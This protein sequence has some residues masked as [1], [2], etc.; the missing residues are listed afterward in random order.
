M[1]IRKVRG[2]LMPTRKGEPQ[3]QVQNGDIVD[4][5][6]G[7]SPHRRE[8]ERYGRGNSH[9]GRIFKPNNNDVYVIHNVSGKIKIQP[10]NSFNKW[11]DLLHPN[12]GFHIKQIRRPF[13]KQER[14]QKLLQIQQ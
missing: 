5:Y 1:P 14:D 8:A 6:W 2:K 4:L 3:T 12:K 9:T 7:R 13:T 10:L 11:S